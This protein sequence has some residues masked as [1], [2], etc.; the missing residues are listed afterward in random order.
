MRTRILLTACFPAQRFERDDF[1]E[2]ATHYYKRQ[3]IVVREDNDISELQQRGLQSFHAVP[4]RFSVKEKIV[5][6]LD[7]WVI[8]R[9]LGLPSMHATVPF[10][11]PLKVLA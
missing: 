9:V 1:A 10:K 8:D 6:A 4:G 5:H 3:D 2:L 7:N 11:V